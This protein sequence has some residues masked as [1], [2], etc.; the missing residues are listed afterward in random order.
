MPHLNLTD[1]YPESP[2]SYSYPHPYWTCWSVKVYPKV[3]KRSQV[4]PS[5]QH[6]GTTSGFNCMPIKYPF[7]H[8]YLKYEKNRKGIKLRLLASKAEST[9]L[10]VH[11]AAPVTTGFLL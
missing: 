5:D 8:F 6:M 11:A 4:N 1:P 3:Q 10:T 2:Q 7:I 9:F